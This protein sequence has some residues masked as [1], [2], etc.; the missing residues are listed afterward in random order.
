MSERLVCEDKTDEAVRTIPT[1]MPAPNGPLVGVQLRQR[2]LY[3]PHWNGVRAAFAA[4]A[5]GAKED[6]LPLM[7]RLVEAGH[8]LYAV[9]QCGQNETP[10]VENPG[11]YTLASLAN[12]LAVSIT[13]VC[14]RKPVHLVGH[15]AGALVAAQAVADAVGREVASPSKYRSLT[16]IAPCWDGLPAGGCVESS[17][18]ERLVAVQHRGGDMSEERRTLVRQRLTRSHPLALR[19]MASAFADADLVSRVR[20]TGLPVLVV[21]GAEDALVPQPFTEELARRLGARHSVVAGAG[22][23][24]HLDAPDDLAEILQAFWEEQGAEWTH[25][26]P[27]AVP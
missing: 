9:D 13:A 16:L 20:A 4:G 27:P 11:A 14:A 7:E 17:D 21:A 1:W 26:A 22:H 23:L 19:H 6:F 25:S 10:G 2:G 24:P 8:R 5:G 15:G 3:N 18:W 12:D